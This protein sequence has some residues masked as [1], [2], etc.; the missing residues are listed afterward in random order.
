MDSFSVESI[1]GWIYDGW[2][3]RKEKDW[4]CSVAQEA[5]M[6]PNEWK[7]QGRRFQL[8]WAA[9]DEGNERPVAAGMKRK[10]RQTFS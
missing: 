4:T 2:M 1:N 9:F 3:K 6:G 5:K 8:D 7:L 10:S